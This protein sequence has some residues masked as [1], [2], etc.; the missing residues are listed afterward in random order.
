MATV[1]ARTVVRIQ[2]DLPE[3]RAK[4]LDELMRE[5][6]ISSRRELFNTALTLLW[7]VAKQR[8]ENRV[9]AALNEETGHYTE[10][11][12]PTLDPPEPPVGSESPS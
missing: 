2:L 9:I 7:W 4:E 12:L 8:K 1:Q 10:L 3:Q 6:N 5:T 11:I